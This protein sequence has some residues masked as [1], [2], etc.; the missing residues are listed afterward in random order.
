MAQNFPSGR[1]AKN[2]RL[3]LEGKCRSEDIIYE[4]V[5]TATGYAQ[6][7]CLGTAKGD[8]KQRYYNRKKLI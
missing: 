3:P 7:A 6:K 4:C 8:F 1:L 5:V 2:G